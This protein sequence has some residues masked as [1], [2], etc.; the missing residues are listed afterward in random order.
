MRIAI[1]FLLI[2]SLSHAQ[3]KRGDA[4][5]LRDGTIHLGIMTG[6]Q[7][8]RI[9]NN[10]TVGYDFEYNVAPRAAIG[11]DWN[12]AATGK[13]LFGFS[14]TYEQMKVR[15]RGFIPESL[16][17]TNNVLSLNNN[18]VFNIYT[19]NFRFEFVHQ[20][21]ER[22]FVSLGVNVNTRWRIKD[23]LIATSESFTISS[24]QNNSILIARP[25]RSDAFIRT[26][27][28]L[29][30]TYKDQKLGAFSLRGMAAFGDGRLVD[31]NIFIFNED[32]NQNTVSQHAVT[33]KFFNISLTWFPSK[34]LFK[35][36]NN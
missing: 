25:D 5:L 10:G 3:K 11:L 32:I 29:S 24:N 28:S 27:F 31:D 13:F 12:Y 18:R 23:D 4:Q 19:V 15:S 6:L 14:T 20:L 22:H 7:V 33:S 17:G 30:Y 1:L 16:F 21:A 26:P 2:A 36:S 8:D 9:L 35:S 34:G